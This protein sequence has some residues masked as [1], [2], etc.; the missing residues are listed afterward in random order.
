MILLFIKI[1]LS[2]YSFKLNCAVRVS[3][4]TDCNFRLTLV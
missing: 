1:S 4:K 3:F 2:N